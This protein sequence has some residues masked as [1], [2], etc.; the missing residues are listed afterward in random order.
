MDV[1][2]LLIKLGHRCELG[3]EICAGRREGEGEG[4]RAG[5]VALPATPEFSAEQ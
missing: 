1:F 4:K 2:L 5:A 3:A